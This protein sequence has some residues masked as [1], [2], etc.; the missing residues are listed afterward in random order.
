MR[1]APT[2][3]RRITAKA[4]AS[5]KLRDGDYVYFPQF[6]EY[7]RWNKYHFKTLRRDVFING[8]ALCGG[9]GIADLHNL[10]RRMLWKA[11]HIHDCEA[12]KHDKCGYCDGVCI[13]EQLIG[14][15]AMS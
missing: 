4:C 3:T 7:H 12:A 14:S 5:L 15:G 8:F 11:R 9:I 10:R 1:R 6:E 2:G 13:L